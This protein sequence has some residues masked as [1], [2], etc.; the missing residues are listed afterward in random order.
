L[1]VAASHFQYQLGIL[2]FVIP[3]VYWLLYANK[4]GHGLPQSAPENQA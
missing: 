3:V 1:A 2:V 4:P